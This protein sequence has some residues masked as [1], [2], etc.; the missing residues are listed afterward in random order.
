VG[1][2]LG[3]QTTEPDEEEENTAED[4]KGASCAGAATPIDWSSDNPTYTSHVIVVDPSGK[5]V[6]GAKVKAGDRFEMTDDNGF[7]R[8]GPVN[9]EKP[10]PLTV[11]KDGSTPATTQTSAFKSAREPAQVVLM[12]VGK[13]QKIAPEERVVVEHEGARVD[14]PEKALV[15]A[16]GTRVQSGKA[17][18]TQLSPDK[19]PAGSMPGSSEA[20]DLAGAPAV[21]GDLLSV[22]YLHF[23]D[24]AGNELNLAPGVAAL[25]EAPVPKSANLKDGESVGLWTLD[26]KT[27]A[28]HEEKACTVATREGA[29]GKEKVC[30]GAVSHFSYWALATQIDIYQPGS[31]GCVNVVTRAAEDA[32]FKIKVQDQRLLACDEA[33]ENCEIAP[34]PRETFYGSADGQVQ[35]CSIVTTAAQTQRVLLTYDIDV[36]DCEGMMDAPIAG[37]RKWLGE[38]IAL[39]SFQ[40][41]LGSTLMLN[42]TLQGERDCPTLCAQAELELSA[43]DLA[44]PFWIDH[45]GDGAYV[46]NDKK[47][48]PL[49]GTI[50]DCDDTNPGIS[51]RAYESFCATVDMNCDG[52]VPE[53]ASSYKDVEPWR[54]N[55]FCSSCLAVEDTKLKKSDEVTGNAYDEDCDGV[56]D[57]RDGDGVSIPEDCNDFDKGSSPKL[58]EEPGNF[59]D[60]NCDGIVLDAD[61]DGTPSLA[62]MLFWEGS[63]FAQDKFTDCD[64]YDPATNVDV[65]PSDEAGQAVIFYY[66]WEDTLRR[67]ASYCDLFYQDGSPN[68]LFYQKVKD[69]NCDG[70]VSDADGDTFT[71]PDDLSSGEKLALD[72]D[73]LDPRYGAGTLNEGELMCTLPTDLINDSSCESRFQPFVPGRTCPALT[74]P[75][76][77]LATTCEE[78]KDVDGNGTGSGVCT[79][80]GW[81]DTNPLSLN[82]GTLW[83]PCDA[84]TGQQ[85]HQLEF[86]P[87]GSACGGLLGE[88]PWTSEFDQYIRETYTNGKELA[89]QGM[90]FPACLI[91]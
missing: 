36:K 43:K 62:H 3:D 26:E 44:S 84:Q 20:Y 51:P 77:V 76:T 12:P 47:A 2:S 80:R 72:C 69:L 67:R 13:E 27:G 31:L 46:A 65:P 40:E 64:D 91:E 21:L 4:C 19:V 53:E 33:G 60:E 56:V 73:D 39:T 1:C 89:F 41:T 22:T 81:W 9:A 88:K 61:D 17:Q 68:G 85:V 71:L 90:C 58:K 50:V 75:G 23:T 79:F 6:A 57:D 78:S 59:A 49:P 63:G 18:M 52:E 34:T 87:Q 24:D 8:V 45:D 48:E 16:D 82:P 35:Y 55:Y 86:C 32:C 30:I 25:L 5:P 54:W 29:A 11:S 74:L 66:T 14:L 37:R 28:W 15:K 7:A 42:F 38:P 83:G 10:Q 70:K